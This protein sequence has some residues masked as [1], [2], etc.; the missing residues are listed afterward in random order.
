MNSPRLVGAAEAG[1]A[2][3]AGDE[4]VFAAGINGDKSVKYF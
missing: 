1:Q 2:V 3:R 4:E